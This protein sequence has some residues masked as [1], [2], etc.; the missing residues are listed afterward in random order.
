MGEECMMNEASVDLM[1][2]AYNRLEFTRASFAALL[3]N[4]DWELVRELAVY[5][6][7]S[8]DGTLEWLQQSVA[9]VPV[10]V[11]LVRTRLRS[12]VAVMTHF[13]E[14][15]SAPILAK[16]DNDVMLP[17]GWLRQSLE[18][19]EHHPELAM[20]GIEAMNPLAVGRKVFYSYT[21]AEF[22]SG[23]GL[24][25]ARSFESS[26]PSPVDRWF[27]FE[28]WQKQQGADLLC[29]WIDPAIP[30]FLLDRLPLDPWG[31][32]TD[33]YVRQRWQRKWPRYATTQS[34]LWEWFVAS[35]Q[36]SDMATTHAKDDCLCAMRIKNESENIAEVIA[37]V[38]PL[39]ARVFIFDDHSSDT[40]VEICRSFGDAVTIFPS[41]FEGI[42]ESRDKNYLLAKIIEAAPEWVL[43]VDGDEVL[44]RSGPEQ[45]RRVMHTK[46]GAN[47]YSLRIA[48]L[49]D[50]VERIRVDGIYGRF[51]RPSL[52]RLAG[53]QHTRLRFQ[54][55]EAG[56]NLH[57]GN[58]PLGIAGSARTLDVR[59]KHYGYLS[60]QQRQRK[61]EW[62]NLVDPGNMLEDCYRHLIEIPGARHAPGPPRFEMWKE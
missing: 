45:I 59:L 1:Y 44:E 57:C 39:C 7:G 11:R 43:W 28:S 26:S 27:G 4:T 9:D 2:L 33:R 23:L 50:D 21:S 13:F 40:T 16:V 32:L 34:K 17:K 22:I 41:P 56:A 55:T 6:D 58:V 46:Q 25:R 35:E 47:I 5:D 48:Y 8:S 12:P 10:P 30:V 29:G 38:L 60:L 53:Q 61:Y 31:G 37:S 62:Y 14:S 52:F 18:V 36:D 49:W 3:A 20:L 51:A 24:Y 42:D 54:A 15:A 19:L